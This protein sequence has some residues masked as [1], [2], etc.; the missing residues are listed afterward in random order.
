MFS[1]SVSWRDIPEELILRY[2]LDRRAI[3]RAPEAAREIRFSWRDP[4]PLLPAWSGVELGIFPW[5]SNDPKGK[6]P[7]TGWAREEDLEASLWQELEPEEIQIPACYGY[8]GGVWYC[9]TQGFRGILVRDPKGNPR[10]FM[11]TTKSTHYW[12]VMTGVD[13]MPVLIQQTI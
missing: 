6:L 12:K 13:R 5:G 4:D 2:K 3:Q 11:L 1:F 8:A 7:Y 10:V 9:V